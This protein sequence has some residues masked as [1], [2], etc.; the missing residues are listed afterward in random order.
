MLRICG[1]A[2]SCSDCA[3]TGRF[4]L[5]AACSQAAAM[6]A[7][8]PSHSPRAPNSMRPDG[9]V[10][11]ALMS[12]T[13]CGRITSSFI[14]SINVVPPA[15]YWP[16]ACTLAASRAPA[17]PC[18]RI[19]ASTLPA[20]SNTNGR[21]SGSLDFRRGVEH[22]V[23][24]V[25][26][27]RATAEIAAHVFAHLRLVLGMALVHAGD[28]RH[29]LPGRAVAALER[30]VVDEGL[31][32]RVQRRA[33]RAQPFDRRHVA[34]LRNGGETEAGERALAV[35]QHGA[36]AAL[37]VVAALFGAGQPHVLAQ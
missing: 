6:R 20:R 33:G 26:I 11:S 13:R 17:A 4:S 27:G 3:I 19:A 16:A 29:D 8:A 2:A 35:D 1:L 31:L 32:H 12:V 15:T 21:M 36:G 25:G 30:V 22:G 18:A 14:R 24:D 23:D 37:A 9:E 34:A 5:T 7:S 28:G 10:S